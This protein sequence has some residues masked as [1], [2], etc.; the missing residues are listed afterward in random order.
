M[1][2]ERRGKRER[3]GKTT[4]ENG[5]EKSSSRRRRR[6]REGREGGEGELV[7]GPVDYYYIFHQRNDVGGGPVA[8]ALLKPGKKMERTNRTRHC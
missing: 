7:N 6:W 8:F 5:V 3:S 1:G 2:G 4:A